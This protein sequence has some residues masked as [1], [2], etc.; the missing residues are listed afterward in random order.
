MWHAI[1]NGWGVNVEV[2]TLQDARLCGIL[3]G[4]LHRDFPRRRGTEV[5]VTGA[6]RKRV[7]G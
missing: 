7:V 1:E 4:P 2:L 6:P 3:L 5:V